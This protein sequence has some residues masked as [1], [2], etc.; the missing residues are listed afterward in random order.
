[1]KNASTAN[2]QLVPGRSICSETSICSS[3]IRR[4]SPK[5]RR[6]DTRLT[7]FAPTYRS[8][9]SS[10]RMRKRLVTPFEPSPKQPGRGL[11]ISAGFRISKI[12]R[13]GLPE[14]RIRSRTGHTASNPLRL[15]KGG[16][17]ARQTPQFRRNG[18]WR[19][20]VSGVSDGTRARRPDVNTCSSVPS[21]VPDPAPI[22]AAFPRPAM[23]PMRAPAAAKP[24][25][26]LPERAVRRIS[27]PPHLSR[28]RRSVCPESS[29][30][31]TPAGVPFS[32]QSVQPRVDL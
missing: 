10:G 23:A 28:R 3:W 1:M 19:R 20:K 11:A 9:R 4:S 14:S 24:P 32:R 21:V 5:F 13:L 27:L 25:I 16:E 8:M 17:S 18:C 22:A 6:R 12:C 15:Q 31:A 26:V 7:S 29:T 30:N 2:W